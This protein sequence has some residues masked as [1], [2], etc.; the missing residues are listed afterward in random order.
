MAE[1]EKARHPEARLTD[2]ARHDAA[3]MAKVGIDIEADAMEAYP[4]LHPDA[5]GGD[6]VLAALALVPPAHPDADPVLPALAADVEVRE[7]TD[8]PFL[9]VSHEPAHV[10]AAPPEVKH[11]IGDALA[12]PV[13]GEL[14]AAAG[15]KHRKPRLD[16]VLGPGA[17]PRRVERG[18]L[19]KPDQLTGLA[20]RNGGRPRLHDGKR[21]LIGRRRS[22][23]RGRRV[24]RDIVAGFSHRL[25]M[26]VKA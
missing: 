3:E 11:R 4:A 10:A 5:D 19:D 26:S 20:G 8:Q 13:I 24:C 9:Q 6:L 7:R 23:G 15:G 12:R 17:R 22:G 1:V 21:L 2:A 18:M 25:T 16:K 14:A